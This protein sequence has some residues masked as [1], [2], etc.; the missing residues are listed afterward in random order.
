VV[1]EATG[2]SH[3]VY[4]FLAVHAGE[5][6]M[7]DPLAMHDRTKSK[8]KTDRVDAAALAE[9]LA[10]DYVQ[11]VWVPDEV[12]WERREWASHR[13]ALSKQ[14]TVVKN[15]LRAMLYRHGLE[16]KGDHILD[17]EAVEYA[18][19]SSLSE[20]VQGL[21]RSQWRIGRAL[22]QE[23]QQLDR[24][25][26]SLTLKEEEN[27]RLMTLPGVGPQAALII[28]SAVGDVSRF[29]SSKKLASYA[30]LVPRVSKSDETVYY[31]SITKHGR[32]T[33]GF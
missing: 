15:Q 33:P 29:S 27:L 3:H 18:Q 7:A 28:R 6:L 1:I 19:K 4:G 20:L 23:I 9:A 17:E 31:G 22:E 11:K 8:R 25:L 32:S 10:S 16:Y 14:L 5:V 13:H 12:T 30:G 21:F 26:S 2:N 24:E